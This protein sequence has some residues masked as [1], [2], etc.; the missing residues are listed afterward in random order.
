MQA[1]NASELFCKHLQYLIMTDWVVYFYL[2]KPISGI[3]G[4]V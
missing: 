3:E 4:K 1:L 2:H